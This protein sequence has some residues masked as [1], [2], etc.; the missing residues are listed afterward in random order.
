MSLTIDLSPADVEFIRIQAMENNV[1]IEEFS[2]EAIMKAALNAAYLT[3]I[4]QAKKNAD[5]GHCT[6][7]TDDELREIVYGS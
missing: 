2:Y 7:V 3:R 5:L 6:Y 1:S 4:N